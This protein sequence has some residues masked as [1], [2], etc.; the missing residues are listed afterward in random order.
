MKIEIS[1][2]AADELVSNLLFSVLEDVQEDET[3]EVE[4]KESLLR[5]LLYFS[6]NPA[7]MKI[8]FPN[9]WASIKDEPA[10]VQ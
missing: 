6:D 4:L 2:E 8:L 7:L 9:Q 5:I 3:V 1:V 10:Y